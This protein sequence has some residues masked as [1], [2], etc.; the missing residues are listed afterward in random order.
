MFQFSEIKEE[1]KNK[2]VYQKQN[3]TNS[4]LKTTFQSKLIQCYKLAIDAIKV[5]IMFILF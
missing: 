5:C 2:N 3:K 1:S 4:L